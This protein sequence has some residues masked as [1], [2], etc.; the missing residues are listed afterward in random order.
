ME[1]RLVQIFA[2]VVGLLAVT[3]LFISGEH[4]FNLMNVDIALDI[5]RVGLAAVLI[6]AGFF[7][8]SVQAVRS[9]LL[10][11][12]VLYLG[13][14]ALGLLD[15]KLWG[16]LPTGLTGFDIAFHLGAGLVGLAAVLTAKQ[17]HPAMTT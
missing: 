16:L 3:G 13:L 2:V 10:T 9:A 5:L 12:T 6:Y 11:F 17:H 15:A 14:G 1:K 7:T 4:L 8:K